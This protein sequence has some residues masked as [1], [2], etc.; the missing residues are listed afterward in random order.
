MGF[1][2]WPL[3]IM[4]STILD[5]GLLLTNEKLAPL[6]GS[7]IAES[8]KKCDAV[9]IASGYVGVKA[10]EEC[11]PYFRSIASKGGQV[12]LIFGLG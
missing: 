2:A 8:L 11:L 1:M 12:T 5:P 3:V 6:V 9:K 4:P 7:Y 10:F